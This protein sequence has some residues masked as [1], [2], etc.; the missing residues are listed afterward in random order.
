MLI[1]HKYLKEKYSMNI[2]G[3]LHVGA[4]EGQEAHAY[5]ELGV[6]KVVWVEALPHIYNELVLNISRYKGNV[7]L[8][9]CVSDKDG[10]EVVFHEASNG[11][12]SS[13]LLELGTHK[14]AHP[15][16]T[17][18]A[19]HKMTTARLDTLLGEHEIIKLTQGLNFLALDLQ[20][21]ELMALRGLGSLI[22]QFDYIYMEVNRRELYKGCALIQDVDLFMTA[23]G[24]RRREE[25]IFEQWGWGD[26]LYTR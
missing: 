6:S 2:T 5:E 14:T 17:F 19:D 9:A 18:V 3:I 21:A 1:D 7:A 13:S 8:L 20:G 10:E 22:R 16:V 26:A 11:G 12:Q 15:D 24:F 23:N 4:S 25:R